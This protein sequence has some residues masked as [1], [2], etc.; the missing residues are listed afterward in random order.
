MQAETADAW[1][2]ALREARDE[3]AIANHGSRLTVEVV[4]TPHWRVRFGVTATGRIL[5][6]LGGGRPADLHLEGTANDV[7]AFLLGHSTLAV[8]IERG[9]VTV[10]PG[11]NATR[12][13]TFRAVVASSLRTLV[14]GNAVLVPFGAAMA[15]RLRRLCDR[16][17][18]LSAAGV[19][20]FA[21]AVV[22]TF[23][24][25]GGPMPVSADPPPPAIG[26]LHSPGVK[27]PLSRTAELHASHTAEL[28]SPSAR[29]Q[30]GSSVQPGTPN[31]PVEVTINATVGQGT[32]DLGGDERTID[33]PV[34]GKFACN[35]EFREA[36]CGAA[37]QIPKAGM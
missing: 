36:V 27:A 19:A 16:S 23:A 4:V 32:T 14:E 34:T 13:E 18:E 1:L 3:I 37:E 28:E 31:A 5:Y 12:L 33:V 10:R 15:V 22:A 29:T 11:L 2:G 7:A 30:T 8:G 26:A 21:P 17:A 9:L 25:L 6:P 20:N 24:F 35:S